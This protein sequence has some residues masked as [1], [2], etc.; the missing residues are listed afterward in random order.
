MSLAT[1]WAY[2]VVTSPPV[3]G[4]VY[5]GVPKSGNQS[6]IDFQTDTSAL[7]V[8][9]EGF[10]DPHTAVKEYYIAV[11]TCPGCDNVVG[12]QAV[13][14]VNSFRLDHVRFGVGLKYYTSVMACNT[15][16]YC[17]TAVSDGV[18]IDSSPPSMGVV[19]DGTAARDIEYQSIR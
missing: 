19:M 17:T 8:F 7:H 10:H 1:S 13:G 11:G 4:H 18:I 6:D 15:A 2:T 12:V 14:I 9:W 16:D 3:A 5:D